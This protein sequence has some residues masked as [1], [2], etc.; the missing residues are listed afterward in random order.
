MVINMKKWNIIV[1]CL[2]AAVALFFFVATFHVQS[3][4]QIEVISGRV[5]P[6]VLSVLLFVLSI[7]LI[8]TSVFSKKISEETLRVFTKGNILVPV[9]MGVFLC[10]ILVIR[11]LGFYV[12]TGLFLICTMM[13]YDRDRDRR[14]LVKKGLVSIGIPVVIYLLFYRLLR[15]YLPTGT[16]F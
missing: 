15:V 10:Y 6:Y 4:V 12:S 1:S 9:S 7:I 3:G 16:L 8:L 11:T 13:L 14:S 5:V 2:F